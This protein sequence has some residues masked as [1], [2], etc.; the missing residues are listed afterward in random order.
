MDGLAA[1][2][3][4]GGAGAEAALGAGE[5]ESP[6]GT[7]VWLLN[8]NA[9]DST[10]CRLRK[11]WC[12]RIHVNACRRRCARRELLTGHV[13]HLPVDGHIVAYKWPSCLDDPFQPQN[14]AMYQGVAS[15]WGFSEMTIHP[16]RHE[17]H[18]CCLLLAEFLAFQP[19]KD[20]TSG[21]RV[22]QVVSLFQ[23]I[24]GSSQLTWCDGSHPD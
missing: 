7:A 13:M 22:E 16:A 23:K 20:N 19:V 18:A 17:C 21:T 5:D 11:R 24:L 4:T 12:H 3:A 8:S 1:T 9:I 14:A 10:T 2:S 15:P 6:S